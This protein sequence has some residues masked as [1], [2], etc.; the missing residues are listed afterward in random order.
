[1]RKYKLISEAYFT[2]VALS[3]NEKAAPVNMPVKP[4]TILEKKK[5]RST[6]KGKRSR[7]KIVIYLVSQEW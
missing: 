5:F 2:F 3:E 4:V 6:L 7:M 1:M